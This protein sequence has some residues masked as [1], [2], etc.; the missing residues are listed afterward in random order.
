MSIAI[1]LT[2]AINVMQLTT[3]SSKILEFIV[4]RG[5]YQT[6]LK[7]RGN[8]EQDTANRLACNVTVARETSCSL[9]RLTMPPRSFSSGNFRRVTCVA[10]I[11]VLACGWPSAATGHP[12][13]MLEG[14][15]W[16]GRGWAR[17]KERSSN[18]KS[19]QNGK[20]WFIIFFKRFCFV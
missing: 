18:T 14:S 2:A 12:E 15:D 10:G 19:C 20:H 17:F 4:K 11:G 1:P 5:I 8:H 13:I 16:S 7:K 3:K 9:K 6:S